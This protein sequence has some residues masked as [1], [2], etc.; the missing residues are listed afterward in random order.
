MSDPLS[1]HQLIEHVKEEL[2][3]PTT[4]RSMDEMYPFL[5]VDEVELEV[6]VA[7]VDKL[8]GGMKVSLQVLE[9]GVD[10]EKSWDR[11]HTV[12]IK[13][14]PLLTKEE[15]RTRLKLDNRLWSRIEQTTKK[16]TVKGDDE[17]ADG[18]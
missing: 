15:M 12:K 2:L 11:A 5:F 13:L 9:A 14:S 4:A 8:A 10:P 17:L 6:K 16:A 1:L 18:S 7:V 3:T